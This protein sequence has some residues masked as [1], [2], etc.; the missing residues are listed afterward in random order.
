MIAVYTKIK[1]VRC[2]GNDIVHVKA[3]HSRWKLL[4]T[5][6]N[7]RDTLS[8]NILKVRHSFESRREVVQHVSATALWRA[9]VGKKL[10]GSYRTQIRQCKTIV[11]TFTRLLRSVQDA[12]KGKTQVST[13][14]KEIG[15]K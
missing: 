10:D 12:R 3:G 7:N 6:L 14:R 2:N 9:V 5:S 11:F 1:R 8:N 15:K 4:Q 13:E